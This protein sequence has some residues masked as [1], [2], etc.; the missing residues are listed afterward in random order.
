[1]HMALNTPV[2][3]TENNIVSLESKKGIHSY[4][5]TVKVAFI[6]TTCIERTPVYKDRLVSFP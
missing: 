3:E 6:A 2:L 4:H 5:S 1:M